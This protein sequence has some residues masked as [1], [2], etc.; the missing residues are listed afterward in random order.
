MAI[1]RRKLL[2][3]YEAVLKLH[4]KRSTYSE[5]GAAWR[6]SLFRELCGN[7]LAVQKTLN[8][9][10]SG[11]VG[12]IG[13]HGYYLTHKHFWGGNLKRVQ[14]L[15]DVI[16]IQRTTDEPSLGF[17]AGS[18][19]WFNP[20]ALAPLHTIPEEYLAFE[21]EG[22]QQDGTL[23]HAF[24]RI[25]SDIARSAGYSSTSLT[26]GGDEISHITTDY[27]S[28]PVLSFSA[29]QE[30]ASNKRGENIRRA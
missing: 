20:V 16:G 7:S 22:G 2:D 4:T 30:S 28:V 6:S 29:R 19:F 23:A 24:E 15:L 11:H 9:L 18:M 26:L 25:F 17:F 14:S 27:H 10:R 5:K 21:P 1:H 3:P 13:P 12:I 8:L